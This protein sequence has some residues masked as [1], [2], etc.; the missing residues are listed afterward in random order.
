MAAPEP[1]IANHVFDPPAEVLIIDND[2]AHAETVAESL[3]RI[4][5]PLPGGHLRQAR[6]PG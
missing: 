1:N 5:L 4:G 2:Q 3:E 6:A